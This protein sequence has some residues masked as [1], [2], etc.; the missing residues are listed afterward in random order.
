[1]YL[2]WC[3]FGRPAI[4]VDLSGQ[5]SAVPTGMAWHGAVLC[6]RVPYE[7]GIHRWRDDWRRLELR[8]GPVAQGLIP[9]FFSPSLCCG[10]IS[11]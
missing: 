8:R 5:E 7:M 2:D 9:F 3:V 11:Q 4:V 1:M 6:C 10:N